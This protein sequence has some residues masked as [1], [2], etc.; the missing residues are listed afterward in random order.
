MR[1]TF[2]LSL[3]ALA[4]LPAPPLPGEAPKPEET[5]MSGIRE[6]H[7]R[8]ARPTDDLEAV[9]AFYRDGLGFEVIGSFE[10]HEGFDGVMLGHRG[11][12][13]HLEL[14][15]QRGHEVGR[16]PNA[17]HLLV[18][19]LPDEQAWQAAVAHMKSQGHEPVPSNNPYWDRRGKTFE[20]PDG[21]RVVLQN[22]AWGD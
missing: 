8:I 5:V 6:A 20:D 1:R 12:G 16:A 17:E 15:H 14:T 3:I 10:D 13:Y 19:Y 2:L 4:A 11:T 9:V 7:L 18:F 21:Y 22:A